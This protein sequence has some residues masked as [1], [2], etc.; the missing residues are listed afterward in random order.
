MAGLAQSKE[1]GTA[2][3]R[4]AETLSLFPDPKKKGKDA[5]PTADHLIEAEKQKDQPAASRASNGSEAK[6][7]SFERLSAMF[8]GGARFQLPNGTAT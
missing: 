2:M 7:G 4:A 5:P 1:G 8:G 6:A 3:A